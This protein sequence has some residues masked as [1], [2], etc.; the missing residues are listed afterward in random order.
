MGDRKKAKS[1]TCSIYSKDKGPAILISWLEYLKV[2]NPLN[3]NILR[4]ENPSIIR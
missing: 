4:L 3:T 1:N 2:P